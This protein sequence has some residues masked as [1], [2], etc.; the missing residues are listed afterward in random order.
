[1]QIGAI[2]YHC[3]KCTKPVTLTYIPCI[4]SNTDRFFGN[5][6]NAKLCLDCY[7]DSKIPDAAEAIRGFLCH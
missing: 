2:K 5:M 1:M 4:Q 7:T 3:L 6:L